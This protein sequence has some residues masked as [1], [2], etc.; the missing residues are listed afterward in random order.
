MAEGKYETPS[1][2][3]ILPGFI[4]FFELVLLLLFISFMLD[5]YLDYQEGT[6][7]LQETYLSFGFVFLEFG[8]IAFIFHF[9]FYSIIQLDYIRGFSLYSRFSRKNFEWDQ[10]ESIT[11]IIAKE[12]SKISINHGLMM[13]FL[14]PYF[15]NTRWVYFSLK[16]TSGKEFHQWMSINLGKINQ[17][18]HLLNDITN[19]NVSKTQVDFSALK[20]KKYRNPI[21]DQWLFWRS[22]RPQDLIPRDIFFRDDLG[23]YR[24]KKYSKNSKIMIGF[25]SVSA[26]CLFGCL[27]LVA[28]H[29][30]LKEHPVVWYLFIV[31]G[32]ISFCIGLFYSFFTPEM[33]T[34]PKKNSKQIR[35]Y[36]IKEFQK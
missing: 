16:L 13:I 36:L 3:R 26:F 8:G 7:S 29:V 25:G 34:S 11:M 12:G 32:G 5:N 9:F 14:Y 28:G 35:N 23:R 17:I 2:I 1:R 19:F 22:T 15:Y 10:I 31:V 24:Q 27:Y 18:F 4:I 30:L 6:F 21:R 20:G 33:E